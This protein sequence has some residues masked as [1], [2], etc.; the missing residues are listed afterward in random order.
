MTDFRSEDLASFDQALQ[1]IAGKYDISVDAV[2]N[3][4][5]NDPVLSQFD[6]E[7]PEEW[8]LDYGDAAGGWQGPAAAAGPGVLSESLL[9]QIREGWERVGDGK[10]ED[11][12]SWSNVGSSLLRVIDTPRAVVVSTVKELGD[13]FDPDE[14]F[15]L[16]EWTDQAFGEQRIGFGDVIHDW[17]P[18][19]GEVELF[20]VKPL[21][22]IAGFVGDVALDPFTW[23]TL[24]SLP[25]AKQGTM[26]LVRLAARNGDV[27]LARGMFNR[28]VRA[29]T[30]DDLARLTQVGRRTGMIGADEAFSGGLHFRVPGSKTISRMSG[31]PARPHTLQI[32]SHDNKL[33][34]YTPR[35]AVNTVAQRF[36]RSRLGGLLGGE[37]HKLKKTLLDADASDADWLGAFH[38]IEANNIGKGVARS[39]QNQLEKRWAII[40]KKLLDANVSGKQAYDALGS[41]VPPIGFPPELHKELKDFAEHLRTEANVAV[42]VNKMGGEELEIEEWIRFREDWQPAVA[43][44]EWQEWLRR[45][46]RNLTEDNEWLAGFEQR[47][48]IADGEEFVG[49]RLVKASEH[50]RGLTPRQQA[51][52]IMEDILAEQGEDFLKWFDDDLFSAMEQHISIVSRR[53]QGKFVENYLKEMGVILSREVRDDAAIIATK[54]YRFTEKRIAEMHHEQAVAEAHSTAAARLADDA[55]AEEIDAARRVEQAR[56]AQAERWGV[57]LEEPEGAQVWRDIGDDWNDAADEARAALNAFNDKA[58]DALVQAES[59]TRSA[60]RT[61]EASEQ[62]A[63]DA[64]DGLDKLIA[65]RRQLYAE[66]ENIA[67]AIDNGVEAAT[68]FLKRLEKLNQEIRE[69]DDVIAQAQADYLVRRGELDG[70]LDTAAKSKAIVE[71]GQKTLDEIDEAIK[72]LEH[73]YRTPE[74]EPQVVVRA[75]QDK[76][77]PTLQALSKQLRLPAKRVKPFGSEAREYIRELKR[78]KSQV[79]PLVAAHRQIVSQVGAFYKSPERTLFLDAKAWREDLVA[80]LDEVNELLEGAID[81][82]FVDELKLVLDQLGASKNGYLTYGGDQIV[83]YHG[84]GRG[85]IDLG[86]R[87]EISDMNTSE[88]DSFLGIHLAQNMEFSYSGYARG[89]AGNLAGFFVRSDSPAIF[90]GDL[91]HIVRGQRAPETDPMFNLRSRGSGLA[92]LHAKMLDSGVRNGHYTVEILE[93]AGVPYAREIMRIVERTGRPFTEVAQDFGSRAVKDEA[94]RIAGDLVSD[95]LRNN[96]LRDVLDEVIRPDISDAELQP[97]LAGVLLG[98]EQQGKNT[99]RLYSVNTDMSAM[100][101][102]NWR[103]APIDDEL[104]LDAAFFEEI[105]EAM[106]AG[107]RFDPDLPLVGTDIASDVAIL[108]NAGGFFDDFV[109]PVTSNRWT[110]P[111]DEPVLRAVVDGFVGDLRGEGYDSIMYALRSDQGSWAVIPLS[112]AQ[113]ELPPLGT[114]AREGGMDRTLRQ[115]GGEDL[116]MTT[117][118]GGAIEDAYEAAAVSESKLS[119]VLDQD[120]PESVARIE[121][122]LALY[123]SQL[124]VEVGD[125]TKLLGRT[126]KLQ[127]EV[128]NFVKT[129]PNRNTMA[130]VTKDLAA[131]RGRAGQLLGSWRKELDRLKAEFE[132]EDIAELEEW[133]EYVDSSVIAEVDALV[134]SLETMLADTFEVSQELTRASRTMQQMDMDY[135]VRNGTEDDLVKTVDQAVA[136]LR[137]QRMARMYEK[138]EEAEALGDVITDMHGTAREAQQQVAKNRA[139]VRELERNQVAVETRLEDEAFELE[140]AELALRNKADEAHRRADEIEDEHYRRVQQQFNDLNADVVVAEA[141]MA[142]SVAESVR[143]QAQADQAAADLLRINGD[144]DLLESRFAKMELP[145][146]TTMLVRAMEGYVNIGATGQIPAEVAEGLR[147]VNKIMG[148][149]GSNALVTVIDKVNDLFKSWAI[150]SPGFHS[151]NFFGGAFNNALAGV[152]V[153]A[154]RRFHS[155]YGPV[156]K[157]MADGLSVDDQVRAM[158]GGK[159]ARKLAQTEEG[160]RILTGMEQMIR[161]GMLSGGQTTELAQIA[162]I[163]GGVGGRAY[164]PF[165]PN[166]LVT[167]ALRTPTTHVENYLRGSLALD[168]FMKGG[169]I[170]DAY[171]DV[172]KYH[173]DYDDLSAFERGVMR[174]AVPFYTWTRKNLPLQLEMMLTNPKVYN[175]TMALKRELE[176]DAETENAMPKWIAERFHIQLPM[177]IGGDSMVLVPDLPFTDVDEAFNLRRNLANTTPL[178]KVPLEMIG[179]RNLFFDS[180]YR[181]RQQPVPDA[182]RVILAPAIPPLRALGAV[183]VDEDGR[184]V[185]TEEHMRWLESFMPVM[186]TARRLVPTDDDPKTQERWFQNLVN[187]TFGLGIRRITEREREFELWRRQ[188]PAFFGG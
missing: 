108:D 10:D 100:Q 72:T 143:L 144:V 35:M 92:L 38:A 124:E 151:R 164:N 130:G 33:L 188:N 171:N 169:T 32:L 176:R 183:N 12:F 88:L 23:L 134:R 57:T 95:R 106:E 172:Y 44:P 80:Q 5:A 50:P 119:P 68:P 56:R 131:W 122:D 109:Y 161:F 77:L 105:R 20:G 78:I 140:Q 65:T 31:G 157:A 43:T 126:K 42:T 76:V 98:M 22:N 152:D 182:W 69:L 75:L 85:T 15:S 159:R 45:G 170:Q 29:A 53:V 103:G 97:L 168:R 64:L 73:I 150:A 121:E 107:V 19:L 156:R 177:S 70:M 34:R 49:T 51:I 148:A 158:R 163:R 175:R 117:S 138:Y 113:L 89:Q 179:K 178:L 133:V 173:F 39:L 99:M 153:D 47:A 135:I 79:E 62:A 4:V 125:V 24:G 54:A 114:T 167:G 59:A 16:N 27:A 112:D 165:N 55:T 48:K 132:I 154:Y 110:T 90:G 8:A 25:L 60:Q 94:G 7:N 61:L 145:E 17:A 18:G 86:Q 40:S 186:G 93:R 185:A 141:E 174:R 83:W 162:R 123:G 71:G 58:D 28:G 63:K 142:A 6:P 11:F 120:I 14:Q 2:Q 149:R 91:G 36:R 137:D 184:L 13:F 181:G 166:N 146:R 115:P 84:S 111:D 129:F 118:R 102:M 127:A 116:S 136:V 3:V 66:G 187:W 101:Q 147:D 139:R 74:Y 46:R 1:D 87:P 96:A 52:E 155:L 21:D 160:Q 30:T 9:A 67:R 104:G 128:Q 37:Q 81:P 180:A 82:E 41:D 26:G